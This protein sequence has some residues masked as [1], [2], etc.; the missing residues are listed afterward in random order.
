MPLRKPR[1]TETTP[2]DGSA[3]AVRTPAPAAPAVTDSQAL[4]IP[5]HL[6]EQVVEM[7]QQIPEGNDSGSFGILERLLAAES[8]Q[9]LNK[10][11]DGTSGRDLAG[12]RLMITSVKRMP[13]AY[14]AGPEIFLVVESTDTATGDKFTW[15]TSALAVI[16]QLAYAHLK[17]Y[18]PM[19]AEITAAKKPTARGFVPYHLTIQEIRAIS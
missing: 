12:R 10:P 1:G 19:V 14:D 7:V 2:G 5:D 8:W 15:T 9:D 17:N 13:S 6:L 4:A 18:L 16:V 11:W 3:V